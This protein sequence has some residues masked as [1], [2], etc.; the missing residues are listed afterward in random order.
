[1]EFKDRVSARMKALSLNATDIS[2]LTGVSKATVS[3]WVS[4]TNGA[5][6]KNL[7]A[8]AKALKCSPDW[9]SEGSGSAID[10]TTT[11]PKFGS[12]SA[13]LVAHMLATKAGKNLSEK[14]R[15]RMLAAAA[16]LESDSTAESDQ[17]LLPA[18]YANLRPRKEEILIP[19]YDV[20]GAMGHGQVPADYNEAVRNL[21]V[22]EDILREKGVSY[23]SPS[24]LAMITGWGQSMEGTINDKDLVIVDRGINEFIGE[25]IYLLTWHQELYIKR[26][27]RL[28]EDHYR[29]ISD[30]QHYENQTARIDDVA[31]HAKVLF[32]WNGRKV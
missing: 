9:L 17:T 22:R 5:K 19:Q 32:I 7:L 26:M 2:R 25:G 18:S 20:R 3:F 31:I 6:G 23:S 27:M 21:V 10:V 4:G 28:N 13:E 14:V 15:E 29:L 12:T 30:N 16:E 8:L 1:M 11:E 24:A